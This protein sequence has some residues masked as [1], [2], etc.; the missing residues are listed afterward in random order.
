MDSLSDGSDVLSQDSRGKQHVSH[1]KARVS[2]SNPTEYLNDRETP[3]YF[4]PTSACSCKPDQEARVSG[5]VKHHP[6]RVLGFVH[7]WQDPSKAQN[8][9]NRNTDE[10]LAFA[11]APQRKTH[12]QSGQENKAATILQSAW[13][14]SHDSQNM[15]RASKAATKIQAIFRG[16]LTRKELPLGLCSSYGWAEEQKKTRPRKQNRSFPTF[17]VFHPQ[18]SLDSGRPA[19]RECTCLSSHKPK[20]YPKTVIENYPPLNPKEPFVR[21]SFLP[22]SRTGFPSMSL[23]LALEKQR[24]QEAAVTI[25]AAWRAY[26]NRQKRRPFLQVNGYPFPPNVAVK[27]AIWKI[28]KLGCTFPE[29]GIQQ[30]L[31]NSDILL[32]SK[33]PRV[34]NI[35]IRAV[36]KGLPVSSPMPNISVEVKSPHAVIQGFQRDLSS[37][38]QA[39]YTMRNASASGVSQILIHVNTQQGK[40]PFK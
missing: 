15:E 9:S 10:V 5:K 20:Y 11:P 34:R 24:Y 36:V 13:K 33:A 38:I 40:M 35:N 17:P 32:V 6:A 39:V 19:E 4:L 2:I 29:E 14:G 22:A 1:K 3:A 30:V 28:P 12:Q 26:Q 16:Y 21:A 7:K 27:Q 8:T 23:P 37:G 18:H 31:G 25:Q